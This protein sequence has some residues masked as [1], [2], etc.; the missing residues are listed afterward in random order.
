VYSTVNGDVTGAHGRLRCSII[1]AHRLTITRRYRRALTSARSRVA[2]TIALTAHLL[3]C[4]ADAGPGEL[5]TDRYVAIGGS[6]AAGVQA[7]GITG[8]TQRQAYPSLV[9]ALEGMVFG[10]RAVAGPGCPPP[11]TEPLP[12]H[13]NPQPCSLEGSP[14][15]EFVGQNVAV[16][17]TRVADALT[18]PPTARAPLHNVLLGQRTQVAM[19]QRINATFVTVH[20]GDEDVRGAA[21]LGILGPVTTGGDSLLTPMSSFTASYAALADVLSALPDLE[22]AVLIGIADPIVTMP[23]LQ[24]GGFFFAARDAGG[25]YRGKT[26]NVNCSP[27][28][29]LGQPNPLARNMVSAHI[30]H[31]GAHAEINC[32]PNAYA[33]GDPRRGQYLLDTQEQL[34]LAARV[35]AMNGVIQEIAALNQWQYVDPNE[36]LAPYLA[37][38]DGSGRYQSIRKCQLL[39]A[40]TTPAQ[41]QAAVLN[42][43]PVTGPTAAPG[44]FGELVSFDGEHPSPTFH[45]HLAARVSAARGAA[46][47]S[48][49]M[50]SSPP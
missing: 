17:G 32:D 9:A 20:L 1:N 41:L 2:C 16:P 42:S 24:P 5:P 7:G 47:A 50:S 30:T 49:A 37:Q 4:G 28:T 34:I 14:P 45:L 25:E 22:M 29:S 35:S 3:G 19:L 18:L 13:D 44:I 48:A 11:A 46:G 27:V 31:D 10:V 40:A 26:V 21:R 43:C 6:V 15:P 39:A 38:V 8:S 33:A 23:L 12:P 36:L